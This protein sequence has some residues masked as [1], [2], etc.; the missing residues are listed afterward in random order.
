M[1]E[2]ARV[3]QL[4]EELGDRVLGDACH[5][6]GRANGVSLDEGGDDADA[7]FSDRRFMPL[8]MLERLRIVKRLL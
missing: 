2:L 6:H 4:D 8:I 5:A 7:I 3:A 1:E